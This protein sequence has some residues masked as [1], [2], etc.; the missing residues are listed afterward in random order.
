MVGTPARQCS[1]FRDMKLFSDDDDRK[2]ITLALWNKKCF[3]GTLFRVNFVFKFP[4]DKIL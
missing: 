1:V 2:T 3:S 4:W